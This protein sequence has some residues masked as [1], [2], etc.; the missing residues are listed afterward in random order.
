MTTLHLP[1]Q[2]G[3]QGPC[4]LF[5]LEST[6]VKTCVERSVS[7]KFLKSQFCNVFQVQFVTFQKYSCDQFRMES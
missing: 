2:L 7:S 1:W 5:A 4:F 6:I 3:F